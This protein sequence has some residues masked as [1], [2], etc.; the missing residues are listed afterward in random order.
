[1]LWGSKINIIYKY[2]FWPKWKQ[3]SD[4]PEISCKGSRAW[5]LRN[6][7]LERGMFSGPRKNKNQEEEKPY[8][9]SQES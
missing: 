7:K 1:M 6:Q 4:E 5:L 9:K 8:R 2:I 3:N